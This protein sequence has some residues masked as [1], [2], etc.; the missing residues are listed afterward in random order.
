MLDGEFCGVEVQGGLKRRLR[1][2]KG[3]IGLLRTGREGVGCLA[4]TFP[5]GLCS[6]ARILRIG[7]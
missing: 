4:C 6:N 2:Y 7:S 3:I 5:K 1:V